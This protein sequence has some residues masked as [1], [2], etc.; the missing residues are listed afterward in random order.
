MTN[1]RYEK[2]YKQMEKMFGSEMT[3]TIRERLEAISKDF[4]TYQ[5]EAFG[6][7]YGRKLLDTK[8]RELITIAALT[9]LG[10][11]TNQLK[12]HLKG[13]L[14]AGCTPEELIEVIM[15]MSLYAGFPAALNALYTA[16]EVFDEEDD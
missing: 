9:T 14:R 11:A 3:Q 4:S 16:K 13:A 8:T 12:V 10:H 7:I 5:F 1:K 2:G 6:S 15:Q